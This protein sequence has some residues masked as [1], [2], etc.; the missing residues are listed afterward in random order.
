MAF[1]STGELSSIRAEANKT[2]PSTCTISYRTFV[3]DGA[4]GGSETWVP[5]GTTFACRLATPGVYGQAAIMQSTILE[6]QAFILSLEY[7]ETIGLDDQVT[8]GSNG[9]R[10]VQINEEESEIFLKRVGLVRLS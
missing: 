6:G 2:L 5:R 1:L 8:V 10:V 3:S 7:D 4:G 9:Y